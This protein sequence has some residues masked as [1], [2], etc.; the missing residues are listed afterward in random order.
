MG[1]LS[2]MAEW[3]FSHFI[4]I[5]RK[6]SH[7]A[8]EL[9]HLQD[10]VTALQVSSDRLIAMFPGTSGIDPAAVQAEADRVAAVNAKLDATGTTPTPTP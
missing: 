6:L 8:D 1:W 4:N 3:E 7:M 9:K 10:N 2:K 5:E